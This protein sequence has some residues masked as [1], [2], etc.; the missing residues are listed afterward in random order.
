[1]AAF[2]ARTGRQHPA[3]FIIAQIGRAKPVY[4]TAPET[5]AR[6]YLLNSRFELLSIIG[7]HCE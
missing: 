4:L 6:R 2:E 7:T 3:S 1:M 5:L